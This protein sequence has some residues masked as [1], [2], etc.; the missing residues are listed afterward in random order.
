[1]NKIPVTGSK[2]TTYLYVGDRYSQ[3][4]GKGA[5]RNIFLPLFWKDGVP[6]LKGYRNWR[7]DV[8]TGEHF[9]AGP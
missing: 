9:P 4:T 5:G 7:I 2:A 8:A 3:H 1:M 6:I